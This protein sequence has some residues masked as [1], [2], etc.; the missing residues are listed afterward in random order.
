[1]SAR[2]T[3]CSMRGTPGQARSC[4]AIALE[5]ALILR[6]QLPGAWG[7]LVRTIT[8]CMP[9]MPGQARNIGIIP[10]EG[11]L[12]LHLLWWREW[13]ISAR[14]VKPALLFTVQQPKSVGSLLPQE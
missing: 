11:L 1:M 14:R 4:G 2:V 8:R 9:L 6:Q 13:S 10:L 7:T 3:I 5:I 12:I